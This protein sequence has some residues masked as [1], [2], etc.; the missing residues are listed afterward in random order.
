MT[1]LLTVRQ[2]AERLNTSCKTVLKLI[3]SGSLAHVKWEGAKEYRIRPEEIARFIE[4]SDFGH[5][6]WRF[7]LSAIGRNRPKS[8]TGNSAPE[9]PPKG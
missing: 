7:S 3:H 2:A 8:G 5:R 9:A 1:P 4:A 6:G